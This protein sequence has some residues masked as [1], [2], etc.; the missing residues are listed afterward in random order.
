M[1]DFIT[2]LNASKQAQSEAT[3]ADPPGVGAQSSQWMPMRKLIYTVPKRDS[4]C[5]GIKAT[6]TASIHS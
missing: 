3:S 6:Q 4:A 5:M 1:K 2:V